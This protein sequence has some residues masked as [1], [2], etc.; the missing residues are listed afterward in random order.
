MT[1]Y[2]AVATAKL[3]G[4]L[5]FS[6]RIFAGRVDINA[7]VLASRLGSKHNFFPDGLLLDCFLESR[8]VKNTA[9]TSLVYSGLL[10]DY[11]NIL[12]I[13]LDRL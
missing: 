7:F 13:A 8:C 5:R 11:L 12:P 1:A 3:L 10:H 6:L 2:K 4:S 9:D